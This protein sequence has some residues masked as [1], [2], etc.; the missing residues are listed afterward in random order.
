LLERLKY[1]IKATKPERFYSHIFDYEAREG[2]IEIIKKLREE[3]AAILDRWETTNIKVEIKL[4]EI[5]A[6][7]R[8]K[9][10]RQNTHDFEVTVFPYRSEGYGE[11][12]FFDGKFIITGIAEKYWSVFTA[13]NYEKYSDEI[14]AI[15]SYLKN[16]ISRDLNKISI[17]LL[18]KSNREEIPQIKKITTETLENVERVFGVTAKLVHFNRRPMLTEE[19]AFKQQ[20]VLSR[21]SA[22]VNGFKKNIFN[23]KREES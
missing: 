13:R 2:G 20:Q 16:S 4:L 11:K 23:G 3:M 7:K 9:L 21:I 14:N 18:Q 17:Q 19:V 8:I 5:N 22:L 12:V 1:K 10:L 6:V 15:S